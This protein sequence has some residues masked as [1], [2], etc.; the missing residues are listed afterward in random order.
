MKLYSKKPVSNHQTMACPIESK[1]NILVSEPYQL[2][3]SAEGVI[4]YSQTVRIQLSDA[5]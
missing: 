4:S 3:E 1:T 5:F 2:P